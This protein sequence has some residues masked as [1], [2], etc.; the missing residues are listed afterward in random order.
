MIKYISAS[1]STIKATKM[2]LFAGQGTQEVGMLNQ[3]E[4]K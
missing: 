2:F 1:F 3:I 4:E